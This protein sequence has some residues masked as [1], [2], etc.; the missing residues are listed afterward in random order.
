M[1]PW[2]DFAEC[3]AHYLHITSTLQTAAAGGLTRA[4]WRVSEIADGDG[5]ARGT[6][7]A[8]A[9][10]DE[11]LADWLPVSTFFNRVNRAMGKSDLYPF[12]IAAP[13]ARKLDFVHRVVTASRVEQPLGSAL[14]VVS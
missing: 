13:V 3:F 11:I 14:T 9:T 8:D 2:E 1:H 6:S 5:A 10:M 4:R 7:Y 12:T